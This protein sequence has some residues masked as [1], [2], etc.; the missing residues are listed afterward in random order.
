M[1]IA[2]CG[3]RRISPPLLILEV[4][5]PQIVERVVSLDPDALAINRCLGTKSRELV[6]HGASTPN[7]GITSNETALPPARCRPTAASGC[8]PC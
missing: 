6:R 7:A 2:R 8:I 5:G 1:L 4:T 3:R